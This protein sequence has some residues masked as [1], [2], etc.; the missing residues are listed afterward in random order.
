[1]KVLPWFVIIRFTYLGTRRTS[2]DANIPNP[3]DFFSLHSFISHFFLWT[4]LQQL[5][6]WRFVL[7]ML[8]INKSH[9][10]PEVHLQSW[11]SLQAYLARR[12]VFLM[13]QVVLALNLISQNSQQ[14]DTL[15]LIA[16]DS[17]PWIFPTSVIC[18]CLWKPGDGNI[19]TSCAELR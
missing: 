7:E 1:M 18:R 10:F 3:Y 11:Q 9:F 8:S 14:F 5:S 2:V 16:F 13:W 4:K 12:W 15:C 6:G 19:E 17:V